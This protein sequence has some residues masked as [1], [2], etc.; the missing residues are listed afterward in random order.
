MKGYSS[1]Q[2]I[3]LLKKDGWFEVAVVGSHH[4]FKHPSKR[5]RVTVKHPVK[6]IPQKTLESIG[7][8]AGLH[9]P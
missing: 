7:R 6:D 9:F 4:Q 3:R 2:V 1:R 5:G 8:Q